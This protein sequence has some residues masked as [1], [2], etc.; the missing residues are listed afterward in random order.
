VSKTRVATDVGVYEA[1]AD[2]AK[3]PNGW[4]FGEVAGVAA[5]SQARVYVFSRSEHPMMVFDLDGEFL[6]SWGEG[7]FTKPHN[8]RISPDGFV[9]CSD[10]RDHTVRK[11]TPEGEL[12]MTLGTASVPSDTGA[13][14][15]NYKTV[16][17][18]AGP[19]NG[20]TD[21]AFG[22]GGELY[23]SDGYA[24]ARIHRF[25]AGGKLLS[26]WGAPGDRPGEFCLPHGALIEDGK[27]LY[28][29]DRE[30]NRV[31]QFSLKGEFVTQW[32]DF[33]GPT[34]ISAAADGSL[35]LCEF[36]Y[37]PAVPTKYSVPAHGKRILPR[38][39]IRSPEGELLGKIEGEDKCATGNF[40]AP[41]SVCVD[42][43]GDIYVAEVP[44]TRRAPGRCHTLQKLVKR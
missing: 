38:V 41:H 20:P 11:F 43:S 32:T 22:P 33:A 19:F 42:Q 40:F 39:T 8:V 9:F 24:N 13:E 12:V 44:I 37:D 30:N 35:I 16:K 1:D 34:G 23:I 31:Q 21:I 29:M 36:G 28:V 5:D 7:V 26:S 18:A 2:W 14:G 27:T 17:R 25:S 4:S 6:A 15:G 3:I 10:L